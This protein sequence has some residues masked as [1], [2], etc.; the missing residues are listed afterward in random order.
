MIA[1]FAFL[2]PSPS[3]R[4]NHMNTNSICG[5]YVYGQSTNIIP[6]ESVLYFKI[7]LYDIPDAELHAN[8]IP[9]ICTL[10]NIFTTCSG[11]ERAFID[12]AR[13]KYTSSESVQKTITKLLAKRKTLTTVPTRIPNWEQVAILEQILKEFLEEEADEL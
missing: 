2:L 13:K 8:R 10:N 4:N 12:K 7:H 9:P 11:R 3:P 5:W 6:A 1:P